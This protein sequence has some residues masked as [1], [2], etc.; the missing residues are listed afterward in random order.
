MQKHEEWMQT[1]VD[2]AN[3]VV[4]KRSTSWFDSITSTEAMTNIQ[5]KSRD[6]TVH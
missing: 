3:Y 6:V 2:R 1:N 4:T 5:R